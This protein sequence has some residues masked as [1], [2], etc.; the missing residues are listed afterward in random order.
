MPLLPR[1]LREEEAKAQR[2]EELASD[3][4]AR[5]SSSQLGLLGSL[6]Y[7]PWNAYQTVKR[8]SPAAMP[9]V[10]GWV[11]MVLGPVTC[12][13]TWVWCGWEPIFAIFQ[14]AFLIVPGPFI[15]KVSA[16]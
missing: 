11:P 8:G 14:N 9:A 5:E 2:G 16:L 12:Q 1:H 10:P 3:L 15:L 4:P 13:A 7:S 6:L